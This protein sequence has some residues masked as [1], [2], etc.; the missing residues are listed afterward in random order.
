M[1]KYIF[2]L[3][4]RTERRL[5]VAGLVLVCFRD[6]CRSRPPILIIFGIYIP[7]VDVDYCIVSE[8]CVSSATYKKNKLPERGSTPIGDARAQSA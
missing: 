2:S 5:L 4:E 3:S 1:N 8:H 6:N 7:W